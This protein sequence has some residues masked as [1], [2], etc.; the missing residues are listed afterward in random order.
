MPHFNDKKLVPI[1][2]QVFDFEKITDAHRR[3]EANLNIGKILLKVS[4]EQTDVGQE[5]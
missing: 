3:M 1:I 5:L 4:D 2:D